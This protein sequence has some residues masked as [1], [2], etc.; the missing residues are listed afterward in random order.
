MRESLN[1]ARKLNQ[2]FEEMIM[3]LWFPFGK[4]PLTKQ[5]CVPFTQTIR[6]GISLIK[7]KLLIKF[8]AVGERSAKK[9]IQISFAG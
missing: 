7:I 5:G 9:Y 6:M 8:D 4:F 1:R 3:K 2:K